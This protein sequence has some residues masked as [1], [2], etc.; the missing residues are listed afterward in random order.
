VRPN[1]TER[2]ER[3]VTLEPIPGR[4][5]R[6]FDEHLPGARD[7]AWR[8]G[9]HSSRRAATGEMP[10]ARSVRLAAASARLLQGSR[11]KPKVSHARP[12][13][14]Q[15][16]RSSRFRMRRRPRRIVSSR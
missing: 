12:R 8:R 15:A 9:R 7:A 16:R 10:Y 4:R 13:V 6:R 5:R 1:A 14:R 3:D 11:P 2:G